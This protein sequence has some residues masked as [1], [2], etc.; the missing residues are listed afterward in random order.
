MK[1]KTKISDLIVA[2]V[3]L[4]TEGSTQKTQGHFFTTKKLKGH[5]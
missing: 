3:I 4:E 5:P 1:E 2:E